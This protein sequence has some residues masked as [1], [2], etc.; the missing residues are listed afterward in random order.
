MKIMKKVLLP[1][2]LLWSLS[3]LAD[4]NNTSPQEDIYDF[5]TENTETTPVSSPETPG[6]EETSTETNTTATPTESAVD[7]AQN[8]NLM[9]DA[10]ALIREK[11]IEKYQVRIDKIIGKLVE[12]TSNLPAEK[13]RTVLLDIK[14]KM[15]KKRV[16]VVSNTTIDA[17]IKE[18]TLA[19]LD[20]IILRLDGAI[21]SS[22][23][24]ENSE[25]MPAQMG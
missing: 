14:N 8:Q 19:I 7:D 5:K 10:Q 4:V 22:A 11:L 9:V 1:L 13:Q 24:S 21:Q 3:L 20:H 23:Q 2:M 15:T 17:L 6:E 12:K 25:R 16:S 18:V